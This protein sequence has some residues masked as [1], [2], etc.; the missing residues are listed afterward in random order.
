MT[1][2]EL[3]NLLREARKFVVDAKRLWIEW[4]N[5]Q[6]ERA[7]VSML[8]RI[9]AALAE[10]ADSATSV[11]EW[12]LG[13]DC[14]EDFVY[15]EAYPDSDTGV[16]V[17]RFKGGKWRWTMSREQ[18]GYCDTLDEAKSAAIR[19]ARG[20]RVTRAEDVPP[21]TFSIGDPPLE[22]DPP[23]VWVLRFCDLVGIDGTTE[24]KRLE[25]FAQL[26]D[27]VKASRRA[28]IKA[29]EK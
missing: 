18:Q 27:H 17:V 12:R 16:D 13:D 9:D 8:A 7:V 4:D 25:A 22:V 6:E 10:H 21:V 5:E 24:E 19:A 26:Y 15:Y 23:E 2:A 11:V 3:L 1:N 20:M 29:G 28:A 14:D